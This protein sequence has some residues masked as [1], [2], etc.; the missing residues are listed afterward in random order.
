M[1]LNEFR[2]PQIDLIFDLYVAYGYVESMIRGGS[3]RAHPNTQ[4]NIVFG[5]NRRFG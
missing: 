4:R 3:Q 1:E 2:T 5:S